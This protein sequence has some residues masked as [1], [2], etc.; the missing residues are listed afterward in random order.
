MKPG[1]GRGLD[2]ILRAY[3]EESQSG[4]K[5]SSETSKFA[6]RQGD[7]QK[8]SIS[9][10]YANPNQPRKIFDKESLNELA[11]SIRIHGLIQPIIVDRKSVV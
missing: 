8:I 3:D 2:S 11:E 1:L 7:V 4:A 10:V 9:K 5:A 6:M